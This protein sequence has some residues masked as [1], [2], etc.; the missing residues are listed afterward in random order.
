MNLALKVWKVDY[1]FII[2]NYLDRE[3]WKK[4]WHL[5]T[6]KDWDFTISL[7]H[8]DV[9]D[10][11]IV[12]YVCCNKNGATRNAAVYYYL[13]HEG[14]NLNVLKKK[15]NGAIFNLIEQT[16]RSALTRTSDYRYIA[17]TR[18]RV[19]ERL[20]EIAEEFLDS[21][22]VKND[23]IRNVY[24][25]NYVNNNDN[26]SSEL[27]NYISSNL[28]RLYT[29]CYVTFC[30]AIEDKQRLE[31]ITSRV[32]NDRVQN[33]LDNMKELNEKLDE[34]DYQDYYDNLEDL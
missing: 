3:L 11:S 26:V 30:S 12:F 19:V 6:Y 5:F 33:I 7:H 8:I 28:Y 1:D 22:G 21:N 23:E 9:Y 15:I 29:D 14:Y 27:D 17:D 4:S 34:E 2:K 32:G 16:E 25:D 31:T 13:E 10:M 24:I 20:K 18:D